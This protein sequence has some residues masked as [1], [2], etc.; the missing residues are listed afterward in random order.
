MLTKNSN[1]EELAI[2]P[3]Q[4]F[5]LILS[6]YVLLALSIES[7]FAL[8]AFATKILY[9]TDNIICIFFLYDFFVRL[10]AAKNKVAFMKWGWIDLISSIPMLDMFHYGRVVRVFRVLRILRST[11]VIIHYLFQNRVHGAFSLVSSV[12]ILLVIFGAISVLE[13]ERGVE[14]ANI[15]N[16]VDALWWSF[17][18]ITTVGYGD[19]Y[20]VTYEGKIIAAILMAAGVG[21]FGTFTGFVASWFLEDNDDRKD[22]H[23]MNNLENE[24][25]ELKQEISEL[26]AIIVQQNGQK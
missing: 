4:I 22:H 1:A 8:P 9:I 24:V 10:K 3:F 23:M 7:I 15:N 12:S 5:V 11:K 14:G 26:K 2:G 20:P 25:A 17:V 18:T 21:L 6:I 16:A 19:C 13:F